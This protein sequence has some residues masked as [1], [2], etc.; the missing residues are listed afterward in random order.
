M[1]SARSQNGQRTTPSPAGTIGGPCSQPAVDSDD[2][3]SFRFPC[4]L[5]R[6]RDVWRCRYS[7]RC[8]Q[9]LSR[10]ESRPAPFVSAFGIPDS[11][12]LQA[13][14]LR[15]PIIVN[16]SYSGRQSCRV[17]SNAAKPKS[18]RNGGLEFSRRRPYR[19]PQACGSQAGRQL[20]AGRQGLLTFV[21]R[22]RSCS[23]T[24]T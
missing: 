12:C 13:A 22:D 4:S 24:K 9:P 21:G 23:R 7:G 11:H 8:R 17:V 10:P 18:L 15:N 16:S 5:R 19:S 14:L 2:N 3:R 20:K 1:R 6:R